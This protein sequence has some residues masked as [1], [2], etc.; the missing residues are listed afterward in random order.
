MKNKKQKYIK[1]LGELVLTNERLETL[2][3]EMVIYHSIYQKKELTEIFNEELEYLK[4]K[5]PEIKKF[6]FDEIEELSILIQKQICG[7]RTYGEVL[8]ATEGITD[9]GVRMKTVEYIEMYDFNIFYNYFYL[10]NKEL[11]TVYKKM[12]GLELNKNNFHFEPMSKEYMVEHN[13]GIAFW[14]ID[15]IYIINKKEIV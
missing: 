4:I 7:E 10:N 13:S 15:D 14:A 12:Y 2:K 5:N 1:D 9:E 8:V 6:H 3:S 11:K